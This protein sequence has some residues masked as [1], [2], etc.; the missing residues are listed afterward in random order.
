MNHLSKLE[1]KAFLKEHFQANRSNKS[2]LFDGESENIFHVGWQ[3]GNEDSQTP[4]VTNICEYDC[5]HWQ[6]GKNTS[7]WKLQ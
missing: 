2:H 6:T 7:H 1:K 5:P 3:L 4:S